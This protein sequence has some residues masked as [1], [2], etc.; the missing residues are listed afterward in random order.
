MKIL[1]ELWCGSIYPNEQSIL[2]D[3]E[4]AQALRKVVDEKESLLPGL[5]PEIQKV[6]DTR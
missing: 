4:C 3:S 5:S 6:A 2:K 1:E